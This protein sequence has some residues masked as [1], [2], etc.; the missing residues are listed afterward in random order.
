MVEQSV[1]III[2][3]AAMFVFWALFVY[4]SLRRGVNSA[5]A[6]S[7]NVR[8]ALVGEAR[9]GHHRWTPRSTGSAS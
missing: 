4:R 9:K 1:F 7:E 6:E 5:V 2:V 3:S 8:Q